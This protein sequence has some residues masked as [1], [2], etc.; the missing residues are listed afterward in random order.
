MACIRIYSVIKYIP[1]LPSFRSQNSMSIPRKKV[2]L[3]K[4]S[5]KQLYN[6]E[7]VIKTSI[8]LLSSNILNC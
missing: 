1:L 6:S 2:K 3:Q 4:F 7:N 5:Q 8:K